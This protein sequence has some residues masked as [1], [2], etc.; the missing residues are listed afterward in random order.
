M[1]NIYQKHEIQLELSNMTNF[2]YQNLKT[3]INFEYYSKKIKELHLKNI[4]ELHLKNIKG[5][6]R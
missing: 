1:K 4:K 2:N 6:K 5:Q 3:R